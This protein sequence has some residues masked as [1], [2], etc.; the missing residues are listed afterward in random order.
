M[1]SFRELGLI[2]YFYIIFLLF[3]LISVFLSRP[4]HSLNYCLSYLFKTVIIGKCVLYSVWNSDEKS[5][6][7]LKGSSMVSN[8]VQFFISSS[9]LNVCKLLSVIFLAFRI[10]LK[11]FRY[12]LF[13]NQDQ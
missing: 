6:Y 2:K 13:Y 8:V 1:F 7:A 4:K 11:Q 3:L 5:L 10:I 9:S 12:L